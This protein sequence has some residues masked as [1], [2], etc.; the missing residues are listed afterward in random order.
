MSVWCGL[1]D[2]MNR[3]TRALV[4]CVS[5]AAAV[6]AVLA[7]VDDPKLRD[8]QPPYVG[9]GYCSDGGIA[10]GP[11]IE[12]ASNGVQLLAWIPVLDFDPGNTSSA[13]VEGYVTASGREYAII[14]LSDGTGFVEVTNPGSPVIV[15]FIP[16]PD[17]LWKDVRVFQNFAY[18]VSEGGSGIQIMNMSQI[19]NGV[20]T[21]VG[22][23][24]TPS[25]TS[26][27][28]HT[29]FINQAS[30]RLYRAGGSGNGLR[31]YSLADPANPT[32]IGDWPDRYVHEVTVVTYTSGPYAGREIA[33]C[34]GGFNGGHV[35]TGLYI[36][37][38]DNLLDGNPNN[39]D[40]LLSYFQYSFARYSHQGWLSEDKQYFYLDDELDESQFG[41]SSVTRVIDVSNLSSPSLAS[42]FT[43]G[44]S[45]IDHNLYVKGNLI[46]ES[47]YRSG[48]RVFDATDPTAPVQ[49]AFFDTYPDNDSPQFNGLWD[50]YPFLPSGIV[51]GSDIEKGL[52]VWRVVPNALV[53]EFPD[54]NP[55]FIDPAGDSI[56]VTITQKNG[57][58]GPGTPTLHYSTGGT[59]T[60][61]ELA[62]VPQGGDL[63]HAVF[64]ALP[65][66]DMVH[67]YISAQTIDGVM[68]RVPLEA[69]AQTFQATAAI[70]QTV[71]LDDDME[72]NTGW[73]VGAPGDGATTGLWVLV[74][75]IGTGAAPEDDH[76]PGSGVIC[77]VTGQGTPGGG[78]GEADI[79][80]GAT[81]LTSPTLNAGGLSADAYLIYHR[82]YSNDTGAD[83]NND[84]MPVLISNNDGAS[85]VTLE[86]VSDNAN[87][88]VK[89]SFRISDF[90]APTSQMR[91]RFVAQDLGSGSVVEAGVDDLSIVEYDCVAENPGD[92]NGDG[93]VNITDLLAVIAAWGVCPVPANCP[94]DVAPIG[95]GDG[96]VN[97]TDLLTVISHW[98]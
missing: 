67:Y 34:C 42:T 25:G 78:L 97:I 5:L 75:P 9:P 19:D 46:F 58:L 23:V 85:W 92:V 29:M 17:S 8:K 10:G 24:N 59:S 86:T 90:L 94:A 26:E 50:N 51:L 89:K 83:P 31:I 47:N 72:P 16:G 79:D 33:F 36:V 30:G 14:G 82:W 98:G 37:D 7:H 41:I 76:T 95:A 54:G 35:D 6:T 93:V 96:V 13:T 43:S 56:P 74:D 39:G 40:P 44:S 32:H 73:T 91:V 15:E 69:P 55:P 52:F 49:V 63:Y 65:C 57:E 27:A 71:H 88:W 1:E 62:L 60:F 4:T 77:W 80:G 53:I 11:P 2:H 81:T 68:V 87:E 22:S 21:L 45:S 20:V 18:S 66:G 61:S 84:V 28:T 48:L 70:S 3:Q 64:P 38:I 12:F